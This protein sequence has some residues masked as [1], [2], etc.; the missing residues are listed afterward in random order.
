MSL[1][2]ATGLMAHKILGDLPYSDGVVGALRV[3]QPQ[4]LVASMSSGPLD[5]HLLALDASLLESD[6]PTV[7]MGCDPDGPS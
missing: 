4:L 3:D 5:A 6:N 2:D 7:M 1:S